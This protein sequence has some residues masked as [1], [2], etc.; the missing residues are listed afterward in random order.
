MKVY[1]DKSANYKKKP[2][3]FSCKLLNLEVKNQSLELTT[4]FVSKISKLTLS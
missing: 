4:K 1:K 2:L 3:K